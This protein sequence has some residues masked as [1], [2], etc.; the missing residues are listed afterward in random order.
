VS[1]ALEATAEE[2]QAARVECAAS[3]E[4]SEK[5]RVVFAQREA[6][7][8][9]RVAEL[10]SALRDAAGAAEE[11]SAARVRAEDAAR[12]RVAEVSELREALAEACARVSTV[13]ES[14]TLGETEVLDDST[15]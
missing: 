4:A 13:S 10:T 12:A 15:L 11:A 2:L 9:D 5:T 3:E 1:A 14:A 8:S 6:E 7:L